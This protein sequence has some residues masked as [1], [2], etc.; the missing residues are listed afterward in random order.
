M[1]LYIVLNVVNRHFWILI[2]KAHNNYVII[3][4][5]L[6]WANV[7]D[8]HYLYCFSSQKIKLKCTSLNKRHFFI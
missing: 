6:K 8:L 4:N 2:F 1:P 7:K 5:S 3:N